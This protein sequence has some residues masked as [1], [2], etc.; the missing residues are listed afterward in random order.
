MA[1]TASRVAS[2]NVVICQP[3]AP[4]SEERV[5]D[6]GDAAWTYFFL[7]VL[8]LALTCEPSVGAAT[9]AALSFFGFLTSLLL[10]T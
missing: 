6:G 1:G 8:S 2:R 10:R 3:P 5:P 9:G 4:A 7:V